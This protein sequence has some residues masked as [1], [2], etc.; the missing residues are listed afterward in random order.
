MTAIEPGKKNE[1]GNTGK[2]LKTSVF[3]LTCL[4][5]FGCLVLPGLL[6]N[7]NKAVGIGQVASQEI[8]APY[9]IT[10]ESKVLTE[11]A[12]QS[13]AQSVEPVFLPSDPNIAKAQLD[14]LNKALYYISTVRKDQYANQQQKI[15]DLEA[16]SI[17]SMDREQYQYILSIKDE[18]WQAI[19]LEAY[20]VLEQ[21][22]RESLR[23]DQI[24]RAR[25]GLPAIIDFKFIPDDTEV[26]I[27]LVSPLIVPT[28]LY[29]ESQ[30]QIARD[31]ARASVNSISRQII[32]GEVIVR[33]GQ[34]VRDVDLEALNVFGL[35]Q[36][37]NQNSV[38]IRSAALVAL[39]GLIVWLYYQKHS[40]QNFAT[41]K[42]IVMVSSAFVIFLA[43]ER[44][45]VI[46][47]TLLPYLFPM[48]AFGLTISIV[49]NPELGFLLTIVLGFTAV[50]DKS[51][52]A[53]LAFFYIIPAIAGILTIRHA[54]RI[55]SFL[56]AG[57][58]IGVTSAV[59]IVI[60]RFGDS[61]TDWV[62]F[63]S[64]IAVAMANGL[65]SAG[66]SLLLQYIFASILDMPTALQLM[67]IARPDHPL[68][69][70]ILRNAPGS[71][72]HSLLVSN[73]AEQ[74]AEAI[75]ADRLL[76][77]VGTLYHDV[78][79]TN[80]PSYFIENQIK[81]KID[82]H[83]SVDPATAATTIMQHVPDGIALAKK[84]HLPNRVIDFIR[85]HH[86][87]MLTRYQYSR[88]LE[89]ADKPEEVDKALFTYPGP[90][91]QSRETAILMLADGTEARARARAP[92]TDEEIREV[93][94]ST[95]Q[96]CEEA[97][98]LDDTELTLKDLQTIRKSF[99]E[100][101]KRSYHPRI[102]YPEVKVSATQPIVINPD[103]DS[104]ETA[105]E[106]SL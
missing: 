89:L 44:F 32:T 84:Y 79:K 29:S 76:V 35:A 15:S 26:I 38:L 105:Q 40:D 19:G 85:E 17:L 64:L 73:L 7:Q 43:L 56:R 11:Q 62:G 99:F 37:T 50:F 88:A 53:E 28:S 101:L 18:S 33:R 93:I 24:S 59:V 48:A 95:M 54:R 104:K 106:E 49:F 8:L 98:Q 86:G 63:S 103:M 34:V 6:E 97:G 52:E 91:P 96:A 4:L 66:V 77:R 69:Q 12:R 14:S 60:Y 36:P 23:S 80:N 71:Y 90:T 9:S 45:L 57:L 30:T 2:I 87:T 68:M 27:S 25:S 83:D 78:G 1:P 65:F 102:Q 3:L 31:H 100:T 47:R 46:D 5:V 21:V 41:L 81:E 39:L 92:H 72:Q 82:S 20:R 67:D 16:L 51:R 42:S 10:Y 55:S 94:Q 13:A 22:L 61:Y 70:I 58:F 74:A 75:G